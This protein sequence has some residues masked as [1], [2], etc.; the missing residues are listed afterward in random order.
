[1]NPSAVPCKAGTGFVTASGQLHKFMAKSHLRS[2]VGRNQAGAGL[3]R[4]SEATRYEQK[5]A[6]TV[7]FCRRA[8]L[9]RGEDGAIRSRQPA[10]IDH[11]S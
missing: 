5:V 8:G 2:H 7:E 1:M 3:A 11:R 4:A 9:V 6:R 10:M